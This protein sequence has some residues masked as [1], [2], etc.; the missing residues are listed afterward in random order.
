MQPLF[1]GEIISAIKIK[2]VNGAPC[3]LFSTSNTDMIYKL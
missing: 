2:V 3:K 1:F